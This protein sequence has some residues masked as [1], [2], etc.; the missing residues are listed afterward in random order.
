MIEE[1]DGLHMAPKG[2]ETFISLIAGKMEMMRMKQ[3]E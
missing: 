3:K 2:L 1:R